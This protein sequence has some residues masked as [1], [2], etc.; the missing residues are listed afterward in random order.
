M[1]LGLYWAETP[2]AG[3]NVLSHFTT[4]DAPLIIMSLG[5]ILNG[6]L[7]Y[8]A[9]YRSLITRWHLSIS[10]T[11]SLAAPMLH[12]MP[13]S[14]ISC[15]TVWNSL[16]AC[17]YLISNPALLYKT[18]VLSNASSSAPLVLLGM[19]L[20]V[21]KCK[22]FEMV[23]RKVTPSMYNMSAHNSMPL[24]ASISSAGTST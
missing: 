18:K 21:M 22:F 16:S 12:V 13:F 15:S 7:W 6:Q 5:H 9:L 24:W 10:G 8:T 11:C 19:Y 2:P 3:G 14:S 20:M 4:S 17:R 23:V 1:V